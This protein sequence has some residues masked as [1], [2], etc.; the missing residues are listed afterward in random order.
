MKKLLLMLVAF[1]ATM[2]ASAQAFITGDDMKVENGWAA[3]FTPVADDDE[4]NAA[5]VA[6]AADGSVYVASTFTKS[7]TFAGKALPDP[8]GM[9]S[10]AIVKYDK[11]GKE[12]WAAPMVGNIAVSAMTVDEDGTLYAAGSFT[13]EVEYTGADG[14]K[15]TIKSED[16]LSAFIAKVSKDGKFEAVKTFLATPDAD[17][18]A[19]GLYY[20]EEL[21]V[22]PTT[23]KLN[24]SKLYVAVNYN[25]NVD[26]LGWKAAYLNVFDFMYMENRSKGI[27]SLSKSDLSGAT[28]VLTVQS[29]ER[30][31]YEQVYPEALN[32]DFDADGNVVYAFIG[33]GNLTLAT[34]DASK[35]FTFETTN[36][37]SGIKDHALVIGT[38][39]DGI[40]AKEF[41]GNKNAGEAIP[42]SIA[43]FY[44]QDGTIY[45][46]GTTY[47]SDWFDVSISHEK[48]YA[49]VAAFKASDFTPKW[50]RTA[51]LPE[52][53]VKAT[54]IAISDDNIY[55]TTNKDAYRIDL[56]TGNMLADGDDSDDDFDMSTGDI[57][58]ISAWKSDYVAIVTIDGTDL[59]AMS[60]DLNAEPASDI[61][62][63]GLIEIE[64]SQGS[65]Y[66]D[67]ARAT[68]V[69]G[70]D[71]NTYTATKDLQIAI[72][73]MNVD[74]KDCDYVVV[75][76]AEPVAAGWKLAF[77]SNQDLTDV[78]AGS[79]EFKY[80]FAE[81][82]NCGVNDGVLP[83]ICMMTFIGGFT[84]PLEA[85]VIGIYKHLADTPDAIDAPAI[86]PSA[87]DAPAYNL[88][89]QPVGPDYKGIVIKN[90]KKVLLK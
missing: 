82:P 73:M 76:F 21:Y 27:F 86:A 4:I 66:D 85:K 62:E 30:I 8:E 69:E 11:E 54:A 80:V 12:L 42:Y 9:T 34:P 38:I 3:T 22:S 87:A 78:P 15:G 29:T 51:S 48:D 13:D 74:V 88:A 52:D 63:G 2:S 89:G 28:S 24:G 45:M 23:I 68:L 7:F 32:F 70:D 46:A 43:G 39:K 55:F 65:E 36:D 64:Q 53:D 67:F 77:W 25:A 44:V 60:I 19:T 90:G 33:F 75:R 31:S 81:D 49:F 16:V 41:T 18:L 83:Q 50:D 20:P 71:Y 79:T 72:K 57:A 37:D 1:V 17:L 10:S 58:S 61:P 40:S 84:A 47:G 56:A 5:D 14:V 6:Q 59:T 35:D 26:D